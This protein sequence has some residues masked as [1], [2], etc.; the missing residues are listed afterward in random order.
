[1]NRIKFLSLSASLELLTISACVR[2]YILSPAI[3][4]DQNSNLIWTVVAQ[5]LTAFPSPTLQPSATATL[6][7]TATLTSQGPQEFIAGYFDAIN[8][9]NYALTWSLLADRYKDNVNGPE[10]G[11]YQGYVD[12]WNTIKKVTVMDVTYTYQDNLCIVDTTLQL[13]PYNGQSNTSTYRYTLTYDHTRNTW[14]FDFIPTSKPTPTIEVP[15]PRT[16]ELPP[17]LA[18]EQRSKPKLPSV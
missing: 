2:S 4:P 9:R 6:T 11:G 17:P 15:P 18:N 10:Q 7:P 5:T 14:L 3:Q 12:F 13:V 16:N 1:M 8:S